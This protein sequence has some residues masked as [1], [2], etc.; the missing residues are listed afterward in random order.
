MIACQRTQRHPG[1]MVSDECSVAGLVAFLS[2]GKNVL[3]VPGIDAGKLSS[4]QMERIGQIR[5]RAIHV[6]GPKAMQWLTFPHRALNDKV[7]LELVLT[8]EG[9]GVVEAILGRIE[10]GIYS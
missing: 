8:E 7:P 5:L 2:A 6:L 10:Q 1:T 4:D 3:A 9:G